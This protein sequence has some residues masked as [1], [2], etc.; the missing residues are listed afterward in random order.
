VK[1]SPPDSAASP[2]QDILAMVLILVAIT[3]L[4]LATLVMEEAVVVMAEVVEMVVVVE[5]AK[6]T[7]EE[8]WYD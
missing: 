3:G 8:G 4:L 7:W 6:G 5:D 1:T 2:R